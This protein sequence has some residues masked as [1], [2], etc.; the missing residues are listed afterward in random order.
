[1]RITPNIHLIDIRVPWSRRS[2]NLYLIEDERLCLIDAGVGDRASMRAL[3]AHL[4]R[5]GHRLEDLSLVIITHAHPDHTGGITEIQRASGAE[6]AAYPLEAQAIQDPAKAWDGGT[7]EIEGMLGASGVP[8]PVARRILVAR[9][10][11]GLIPLRGGVVDRLLE[12][13]EVVRLGSLELR[14]I[15]TPGHSPGHLCLYEA[16]GR[17][18]FSGDHVLSKTTPNVGSLVEYLA[19]LRRVLSLDISLIL[20]G[21]EDVIAKPGERVLEII[22]HHSEREQAFLRLLHG[23][24]GMT[25]YELALGHWGHLSGHHLVLALREGHAHLEKL[26]ME[27]GV[28]VERRGTV[29]YYRLGRV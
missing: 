13:G 3:R 5:L 11:R 22:D 17:L 25:L 28:V 21:H 29:S 27:G 20:P 4:R 10:F 26:V 16:G 15:H 12:D 24:G 19:S 14:V 2:F 18:L 1:M 6:V 23:S 8:S 7:E 9:G